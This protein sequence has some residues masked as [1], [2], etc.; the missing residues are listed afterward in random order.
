MCELKTTILGLDLISKVFCY[1]CVEVLHEFQGSRLMVRGREFMRQCKAESRDLLLAWINH[2]IQGHHIFNMNKSQEQMLWGLFIQTKQDNRF[3]MVHIRSFVIWW[4]WAGKCRSWN[5]LNIGINRNDLFLCTIFLSCKIL[6]RSQVLKKMGPWIWGRFGYWKFLK[7]HWIW[8]W[9]RC[10]NP[11]KS[12][13]SH[14]YQRDFCSPSFFF[15][16]FFYCLDSK[17]TSVGH[18]STHFITG[19]TSDSLAAQWGNIQESLLFQQC[20]RVSHNFF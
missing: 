10:G 20:I 3:P 2:I 12:C 4:I 16:S 13:R 1:E 17:T 18:L 15:V 14:R 5:I 8:C 9:R 19:C 7:N 6:K 11:E